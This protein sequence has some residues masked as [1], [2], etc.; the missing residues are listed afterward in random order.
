MNMQRGARCTLHVVLRDKGKVEM[1]AEAE[2]EAEAG[3][4]VAQL[5]SCIHNFL[6]HYLHAK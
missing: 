2:A 4:A 3:D 1:E 6:A 5:I